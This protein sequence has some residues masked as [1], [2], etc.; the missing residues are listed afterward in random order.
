MTRNLDKEAP[1][2]EGEATY[3]LALND[4]I[5]KNDIVGTKVAARVIGY[6]P[7]T[8]ANWRVLGTGPRWFQVQAKGK[9]LYSIA[10]LESW[11]A[12]QMRT[13]TSDTGGRRGE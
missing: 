9:V 5:R 4:N 3:N 8:L 6:A 13:S 10:E 12:S 2:S 1:A 11:L 7:K